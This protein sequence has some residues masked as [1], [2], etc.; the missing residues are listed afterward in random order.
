MFNIVVRFCYC[1]DVIG[2][3]YN[4]WLRECLLF[5]Y[6]VLKIYGV[7][8]DRVFID[9]FYN[10]GLSILYDRFLMVFIEIINSVIDR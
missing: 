6:I 5:I 9:V 7:M 10:F 3:I 1:L 2:S 4:I 8:R